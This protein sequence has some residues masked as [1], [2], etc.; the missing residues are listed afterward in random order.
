MK[1]NCLIAASLIVSMIFPLTAVAEDV[2]NAISRHVPQKIEGTWTVPG[3]VISTEPCV[4]DSEKLCVK[5][6][7]G[8]DSKDSMADILG[9]TV[10]KDMVPGDAPNK[11]EGRYIEDGEDLPAL[12]TLMSDNT[13]QLRICLLWPLCEESN[14]TRVGST[15]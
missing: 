5:V 12:F 13:V 11:W 1:L 2:P 14:Y 15:K 9:Q 8:D 6:I 4:G 3:G 10:V 7:S